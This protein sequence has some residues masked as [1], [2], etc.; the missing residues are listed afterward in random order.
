MAGAGGGLGS[1]GQGVDREGVADSTPPHG[2]PEPNGA[3][4]GAAGARPRPHDPPSRLARAVGADPTSGRARDPEPLGSALPQRQGR[5]AGPRQPWSHQDGRWTSAQPS[6]RRRS[7]IRR[8]S[9]RSPER[10]SAPTP[11]G[12]CR[13]S[14]RRRSRITLTF[15]D[16]AN[17]ARTHRH[18]VASVLATMTSSGTVWSASA[19]GWPRGIG[20]SRRVAAAGAGENCRVGFWAGIRRPFSL[21][22]TPTGA[23]KRLPAGA[24]RAVVGS[25]FV[26]CAGGPSQAH[27]AW[28]AAPRTASRPHPRAP[29]SPT[30]LRSGSER[31]A[32]RAPQTLA[33]PASGPGRTR[34]HL[35]SSEDRPACAAGGGGRRESGRARA[36][37]SVD[38]L[39]AARD[40]RGRGAQ[41]PEAAGDFSH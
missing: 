6:E 38:S 9:R 15:S 7:P 26:P 19:S 31:R 8:R 14:P 13:R 20:P 33:E 1:V 41:K 37:G 18:S 21:G 35:A 34:R 4:D 29:R 5:G 24:G 39:A 30:P 25:F 11:H 40:E 10:R 27:G 12:S 2:A 32:P 17:A 28:S 23:D 22:C 16:P 3:G 36:R